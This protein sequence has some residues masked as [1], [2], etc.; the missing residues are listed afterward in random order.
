MEN[1]TENV[2][3]ISGLK[4]LRIVTIPLL[5][6]KREKTLITSVAIVE[7]YVNPRED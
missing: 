2:P 3:F 6:L 7:K 5:S 1:S 4:G